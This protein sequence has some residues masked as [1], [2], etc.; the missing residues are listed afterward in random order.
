MINWILSLFEKEKP[1]QPGDWL[2][3]ID[4]IDHSYDICKTSLQYN[5]VVQLLEIKKIG[6]LSVVDVGIRF[7]DPTLYTRDEIGTNIAGQGIKWI[8]LSRFRKAT[9]FEIDR[10]LSENNIE[11][12]RDKKINQILNK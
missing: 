4:D 2:I 3:Y 9:E 8:K 11:Y 12:N 1:L 6:G 10:W 5:Q 7:K